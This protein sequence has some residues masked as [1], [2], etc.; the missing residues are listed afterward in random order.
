MA[1]ILPSKAEAKLTHA[2]LIMAITIELLLNAFKTYCKSK[3]P[4][5]P[6][7]ITFPIKT[8]N[9][10]R[11]KVISTNIEKVRINFGFNIFDI[12]GH[13]HTEIKNSLTAKTNK[14]K[15][16]IANTIKG[17]GVS[18]ME[19]DHKWHHGGIDQEVYDNALQQLRSAL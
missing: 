10:Y 7:K 11:Q 15:F 14:P 13:N 3:D 8:T 9:G 17:K 4:P 6:E 16:I 19:N 2:V 5:A 1:K 18:F 12:D